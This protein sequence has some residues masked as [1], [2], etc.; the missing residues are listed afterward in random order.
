MKC[1]ALL[2]VKR[3]VDGFPVIWLPVALTACVGTFALSPANM[4]QN[5]CTVL[6]ASLAVILD[7]AGLI[8]LLVGIFA[9]LTFWDFF[10][11]SGSLLIFFSLI[12]WIFWY[13]SNLTV[14]EEELNLTKPDIL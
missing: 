9:P 12:P 8:I 4:E 13:M 6:F 1:E 14:S 5:K 7:V 3:P 2:P 10:I 11:F